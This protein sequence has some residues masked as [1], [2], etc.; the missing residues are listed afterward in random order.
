MHSVNHTQKKTLVTCDLQNRKWYSRAYVVSRTHA[1]KTCK[2]YKQLSKPF[3]NWSCLQCSRRLQ[4]SGSL[5]FCL[6][7]NIFTVEADWK[8][9][10]RPLQASS[11]GW[12]GRAKRAIRCSIFLMEISS[13]GIQL[14][15]CASCRSSDLG[16]AALQF[17]PGRNLARSHSSQTFPHDPSLLIAWVKSVLVFVACIASVARHATPTLHCCKDM[18]SSHHPSPQCLISRVGAPLKPVRAVKYSVL[19]KEKRI[20]SVHWSTGTGF[21]PVVN[22]VTFCS[23]GGFTWG[24]HS[25]YHQPSTPDPQGPQDSEVPLPS[26]EVGISA[27]GTISLGEQG[28]F[29]GLTRSHFGSSASK[30][31]S[32]VS[33]WDGR[34]WEDRIKKSG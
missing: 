26:H 23:A 4:E 9:V 34:W 33:W 28:G 16:P 12:P 31:C 17:P 19:S 2:D 14:A 24:M 7:S 32:P 20:S 10:G 8:S 25:A 1:V 18:V 5:R 3:W 15:V 29:C 27:G 30:G 22:V 11:L 21:F 6:I 13:G